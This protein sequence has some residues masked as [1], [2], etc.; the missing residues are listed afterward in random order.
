MNEY[1]LQPG[2][3]KYSE[4]PAKILTILGSCIVVCIYDVVLKTG[5][6]CHYYLPKAYDSDDQST[7]KYGINAIPNLLKE[8]KKNGS[9]KE[10]LRAK[11]IGG[12]HVLDA[13]K[14][15]ETEVGKENIR[16]ALELLK[17]FGIPIEGKKV[18]GYKGK[19]IRFFT[20]TGLVQ[21]KDIEPQE[22]TLPAKALPKENPIKVMV[23]DDSKPMRLLLQKMIEEDPKLQVIHVAQDANEALRLMRKEK[24]DVMTL[25]IQ[26][27]GMSGIDFL[28]LYM[29]NTP[30]PTIMV[31]GF[32]AT[33]FDPIMESLENGA[34][35]FIKK[36]SFSDTALMAKELQEKIKEAFR[37]KRDLAR[38]KEEAPAQKE[39]VIMA[40]PLLSK[41]ILAMGASTGGTEALKDVLIRL[42]ENVPPIVIVQHIPPGFSK[43]FAD[44]LDRLCA[45]KAKEAENGDIL[46][47][48]H[49]YVAP[50]DHHMKFVEK[51]GQVIIRITTDPPV[52]RFRPSV[53]YMFNSVVDLASK[54][55]VMGILL[56]GMGD[57]GARGLLQLKKKGVFT[58]AQDESTSV[59]YGMPKAAKDMGATDAV[60]P[61]LD[62]P[63]AIC[64]WLNN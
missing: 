6:M 35:D 63:R 19:K 55:K 11:V 62:I 51:D 38:K 1:F 59:V 8:F 54:R 24:P 17:H 53:D 2:E 44:R 41:Y 37:S 10:N 32:S 20:E 25:D 30:I 56:T 13:V 22:I 21:I 57:D 29:Q 14:E 3:I 27:P 15:S 18:G 52:N 4:R 9:K 64:K 23:V 42:P 49:C 16:I 48:G 31:S 45:F 50:G 33:D 12:G 43:A 60:L 7:N 36:P 58:V 26:M 28:K 34:F 5:G 40:T 39:R 47:A 46:K 61:L